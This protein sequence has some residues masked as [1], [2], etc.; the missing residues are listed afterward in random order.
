MPIFVILSGV[1]SCGSY[2]RKLIRSIFVSYFVPFLVFSVLYEV[3]EF[4][5]TGEWSWYLSKVSPYWL[6]WFLYSLCIWKLILPIFIRLPCS[7]F[8]S[9]I[10]SLFF[11]ILEINGYFLGISRLVYFFPFFL[12]GYKMRNFILSNH[13]FKST[14]SYKLL[15]ILILFL[16]VLIGFLLGE[17]PKEI[18]YGSYPYKSFGIS[19]WHGMIIRF[20]IYFIS[21]LSSISILCLM[22]HKK[23]LSDLFGKRTMNIYL[24]HGFFVLILRETTFYSLFYDKNAAFVFINIIISLNLV[25]FLKCNIIE[26]I[27]RKLTF[28]DFSMKLSLRTKSS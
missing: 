12:I 16:I 7:I 25:F 28:S 8:L 17:Q 24:W 5:Y 23:V 26:L 27:T 19:D 13:K 22:T 3:V 1:F 4:F 9:I 11:G 18:F 21:L 6:L 20:G 2:S 10:I 14:V 15:C